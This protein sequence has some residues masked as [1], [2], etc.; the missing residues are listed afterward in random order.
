M[1]PTSVRTICVPEVTIIKETIATQKLN[2]KITYTLLNKKPN[3]KVFMMDTKSVANAPPGTIIDTKVSSSEFNDFFLIPAKSNQGVAS[4]THYQIVYDDAK[5]QDSHLHSLVYKLCYL[6]YNWTGS[7][8]VPAPCQYAKKLVTLLGEKLSDKKNMYLPNVRFSQQL[9]SLYYLWD[10]QTF[11][12][13][14]RDFIIILYF[15]FCYFE[16]LF[17]IVSYNIN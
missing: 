14:R 5:V 7:I 11:W 2:C 6:Y 15:I 1:T 9:K 13:F 12:L 4:S 17:L 8:K 16:K 3:L 10:L